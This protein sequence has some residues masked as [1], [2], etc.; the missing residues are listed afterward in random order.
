MKKD[1]TKQAVWEARSCSRRLGSARKSRVPEGGLDPRRTLF[2][3]VLAKGFE[4]VG[5]LLETDREELCGP[6][7]RWQPDRQAYRYG[8]DEGQLVLGGR[9][10]RVRKP[11]VRQARGAEIPLPSWQQFASEDPLRRRVLEQVVAGVSA[12]DY[13]RTLDEMPE[14][15]DATA[16]S[17]SS[18]SRRFVAATQKRVEEFLERPLGDLDLPVLMLDGRGMGDH[19]LVIAL[20]IDRSG[21][22]HMLG[23]VEGSTESEAVGRRLLED[24]ISRGLPVER[25][26]LFVIDGGKGLRKAIQQV[27]GTWALVQRCQIHKQRNVLGHLPQGK[28]TW[29]RAAIR[30]AWAEQNASTAKGKLR[31]LAVQL[32][33]DHPGAAASL[34]EGLGET[35]TVLRLGASGLLLQTLS[36]TNPIEN[37]QG[38]LAKVS[39]N[40]KRWR[41]GAMALRWS[42]TGLLVAETKFRRI[43]GHRGLPQL[44]VALDALVG[45]SALDRKAKVA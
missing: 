25:A 15:L 4:E 23:V 42:V 41:G 19:L 16:P 43:K 22:K 8:Y 7:R 24:L 34:L 21:Q 36:S 12:R 28:R 39:R 2:Q 37:V 11:R 6:L 26:R 17:R 5:R 33:N 14:E 44:L 35:V 27:F 1:R 40:V 45:T 32:E 18:V 3:V 10:V 38:T 9:K 31:D 30:R 20:G 13:H 29:V